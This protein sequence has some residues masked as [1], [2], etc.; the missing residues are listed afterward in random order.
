VELSC[1]SALVGT[2]EGG[3]MIGL[4]VIGPMSI[5]MPRVNLVFSCNTW[6]FC[7]GDSYKDHNSRLA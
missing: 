4:F 5:R 1:F 7:I 2:R 6:Q 3:E